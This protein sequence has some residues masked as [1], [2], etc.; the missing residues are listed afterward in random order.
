[1]EFEMDIDALQMLPSEQPAEDTEQGH[2]R[3]CVRTW[4]TFA[5]ED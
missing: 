5:E 1:V 2:L 4:P 3:F